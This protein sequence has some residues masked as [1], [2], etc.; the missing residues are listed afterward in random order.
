M[1][2]YKNPNLQLIQYKIL[3][4]T[5]YTGQRMFKMGLNHSSICPHCTGKLSDSYLH[6]IWECV[7]VHKFWQ[8]ICEDLSRWLKYSI[9]WV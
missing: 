3:H 8:G 2:Q 4:R 9:P 5:H 6:A 1:I 7:P